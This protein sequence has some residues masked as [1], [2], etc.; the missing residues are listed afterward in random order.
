MVIGD[1]RKVAFVIGKKDF[2]LRKVEIYIANQ[3]VTGVNNMAYLPS[4]TYSLECEHDAFKERRIHF[5]WIFLS[6]DD[7]TDSFSTRAFI[8]NNQVIIKMFINNQASIILIV[9]IGYLLRVFKRTAKL[10]RKEGT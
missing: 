2:P 7:T 1:K 9:P 3:L 6:L 8:L 4:Y 10:L 5:D